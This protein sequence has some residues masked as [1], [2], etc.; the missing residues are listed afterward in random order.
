[1][2]SIFGEKIK[3][4]IFGE[5]H[6]GGIGVTVDGLPAGTRIDMVKLLEFLEMRAPGRTELQ[7]ERREE[8]IP[9]FISGLKDGVTCG[10]PLTAIINNMDFKRSDY[11]VI[12]DMPRPGHVDYAAH[13]KY[14]GYED[15][16]GGGHSSGRLT[17]P[18]CIAGGICKQMLSTLEISIEAKIIEIG[19]CASDFDKV[20]AE[21]KEEGDS[22]GGIVECRISGVPA[23]IGEPI[24]DGIENAIART[25]FGI[26]AV[27]GIEFGAG[28]GASRM[29]GSDMN[30]EFYYDEDGR[31]KTRTNN[32]GGILGGISSG[33]DIVFR[34]AI[35]PTPS[36]AKEQNTISYSKKK[37]TKIK[38]EGRHDLCI[39]PRAV[40]CVEAAAAIVIA[41]FMA[42]KF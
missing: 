41:D 2:A 27:K 37:N 4:S 33:M 35:K 26:P 11:N 5:S 39:V 36:I 17:A 18:L 42:D 21:A 1:M 30:D 10:T 12:S 19:G 22:V 40:P 9:T 3:I 6:S 8:D 14:K 31:V 20:I 7:T 32:C 23:G 13:V 25:M 28:F 38:I 15:Y 29:R 16:S 34:V 24:F